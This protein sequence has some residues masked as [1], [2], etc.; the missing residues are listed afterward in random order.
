MRPFYLGHHEF[1]LTHK[2][3]R[4]DDE[5]GF[6]STRELDSADYWLSL[7]NST[8]RYLLKLEFDN[9]VFPAYEELCEDPG[10]NLNRLLELSGAPPE[11]EC[12]Q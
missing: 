10:S 11:V 5:D 8:Y 3:F 2:P 1:R 9:V 4:F 6:I 12:W 7:W